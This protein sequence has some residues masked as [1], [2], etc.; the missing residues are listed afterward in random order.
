MSA[1]GPGGVTTQVLILVA[2]AVLAVGV[3]LVLRRRSRAGAMAV[4]VVPAPAPPLPRPHVAIVANPTKITDLAGTA[5]RF[6]RAC[7]IVGLDPPVWH[8]TTVADPG[9]G[10]TRAA[11]DGGASAVLAYGGDGTVRAV[12]TE[13]AGTSVPLGVIPA[14]TGNLLARNL[15]LPLTDV[16]TALEVA[17]GPDQRRVDVGRV[18]IDVSGEDDAPRLDTFCVMAG[19]GFDAEVMASVQPELK[20]RVGWWAYLVAGARRVRGSRTR[21]TIRVDG[22]QVLD[23]RVRSV[24]V[25]NCGELTGGVRLMP[26]AAVDDGWLDIAVVAP[27][28]AV[29]W[30]AVVA[31]VLTRSRRGRPVVQHLQCRTVE[32]QAEKPLHVQL[33]GDP[34]GTARVLR[35]RVQ[36]GAMTV[37]CG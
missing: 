31:T 14:G 5:A 20:E 29:G 4:P 33:D 8:Q 24:I 36:P 30:G 25:G 32:I 3:L 18:E 27:R 34:V 13:L 10:Q 16:D 11:L 26:E 19:I 21:V 9:H 15:A 22:D 2:A 17:L 28:G 35:A 23:R 6:A 1:G 12:A 37:R 7:V